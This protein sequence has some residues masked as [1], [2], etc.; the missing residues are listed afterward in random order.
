MNG[1][2]FLEY[3]HEYR[4]ELGLDK[5]GSIRTL[6]EYDVYVSY[7]RLDCTYNRCLCPIELVYMR[8]YDDFPLVW[9]VAYKKLGILHEIS[10]ALM[11]SADG[12]D[13]GEYREMMLDATDLN[14]TKR[15]KAFFRTR[16]N[17]PV[18]FVDLFDSVKVD[19]V[20][21]QYLENVIWGL[22]ANDVLTQG[23]GG[24]QLQLSEAHA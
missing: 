15:I 12:F 7:S 4:D 5:Y 22:V 18:G 14:M 16:H 19:R 6:K 20:N 1:A 23:L 8:R 2:T 10:G 3:M 21:E 17:E 13:E 24:Y 9:S 11:R